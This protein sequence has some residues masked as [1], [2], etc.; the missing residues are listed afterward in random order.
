MS[1]N[2]MCSSRCG[3]F[4]ILLQMENGWSEDFNTFY[5][6]DSS[7]ECHINI[8]DSNHSFPVNK[9]DQGCWGVFLPPHPP[10]TLDRWPEKTH[11]SSCTHMMK[12]SWQ[13]LCNIL[14]QKKPTSVMWHRTTQRS[15]G[16]WAWCTKLLSYLSWPRVLSNLSNWPKF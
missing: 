2:G 3:W 10:T 7:T 15:P 16:P 8:P 11:C 1:E 14:K 9:Q 5:L 13:S 4:F 12:S 6:S